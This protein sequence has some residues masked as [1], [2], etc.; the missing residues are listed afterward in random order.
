MTRSSGSSTVKQ[1]SSSDMMVGQVS[2]GPQKSRMLGE[3]FLVVVLLGAAVWLHLLIPGLVP[4]GPDGGNWLAMARD[5]FLGHEV[6]AAA[7]TYPPLLPLSLAG[8]LLFADPIAAITT[9]AILAKSLLVLATYVCARPIGRVYAALAALLVGVAGAQLEAYSWGAYPQ[10]LGT[11]FGVISV[12]FAVRFAIG[13]RARHIGAAVVL[14]YLAYSTHTLIGG[15]LVFVFPLAIAYGLW[16]MRSER[17]AWKRGIWTALVLSLPGA[18]LA[19]YNLVINPDSGVQPVL[20]PLSLSWTES[21]AHTVSEA[22]VPWVII[23]VLG[24]SALSIRNWGAGRSSTAASSAA[25]VVVGVLFFAFI[26]EPRA[27]LLTQLGLVMLSLLV[28]QRLIEATKT[29]RRIRRPW[30]PGVFRKAA[31][32][33]GIA[34][35]S[36]VV[37]GGVGSYI[38][39]TDWYRV[40]D[41]AE[42][43]VLDQLDQAAEDGD[44]VLASQGHHGNPLGWW[45]Q[46]YAGI[47]AYTGVDLR[48]L[49]FPEERE[50]AQIANDFFQQKMSTGESMEML[51]T[52]GADFLVV[53]RRGPDSEWLAG[54][55]ARQFEKLYESANIVVLSPPQP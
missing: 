38:N 43:R 54:P 18:L 46:G 49:T 40:V 52:I 45:V 42:I 24:L 44:L 12:F 4:S 10:L 11:A 50:Q 16:L 53:D 41:E 2:S 5:R 22:P 14:A 39:A 17:P 47:P 20:N 15:L 13:G 6:M 26:G 3:L 25:W 28:F 23:A 34:T 33:L 32:V 37:V 19:M 55:F 21:L 48:F 29:S 8:L 27:L 30:L 51:R 36:A 1:V 9:M 31:L 7:V 35:A